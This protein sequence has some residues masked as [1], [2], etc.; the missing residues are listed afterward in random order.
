MRI[1]ITLLALAA[2]IGTSSAQDGGKEKKRNK[3]ARTEATVAPV[4]NDEPSATPKTGCCAGKS[5]AAQASCG[6]KAADANAAPA[7]SATTSTAT[8]APKAACCAG[9]SAE[10]RAACQAKGEAQAHEHPEAVSPAAEP[11]A[12]PNN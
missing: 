1:L 6:S 5:A 12:A 11:V 2:F 8:D 7:G 3:K 9:R 4:A 10:A